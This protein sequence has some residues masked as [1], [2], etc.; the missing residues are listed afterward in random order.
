[1][2]VPGKPPSP[3]RYRG[4]N[5]RARS[6]SDGDAGNASTPTTL[7]VL[8]GPVAVGTVA[9]GALV[10]G[11]GTASVT[12]T[13]SQ[14]QINTTLAA[15]ANVSYQGNS[16]FNGSDTLTMTTNDGG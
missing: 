10:A 11:S 15:L 13:G 1:M 9:G 2:W 7:R 6:G 5:A 3:P 12:L 4:S 14:S 16:N 8:N